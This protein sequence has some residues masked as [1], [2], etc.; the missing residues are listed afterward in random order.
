MPGL[1]AGDVQSQLGIGGMNRARNQ[2]LLDLNYQNFVGQYNLPAQ[3][4]QGYG[5][6]LTGAVPLLGCTGYSG[7]TAQTGGT[8]ATYG[9]NPGTYYNTYGGGT[10]G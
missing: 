3:L 8:T 1:I 9:A 5:N 2:A 4:F 6:F 7:P 10:Y